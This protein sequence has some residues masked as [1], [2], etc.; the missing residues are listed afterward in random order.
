MTKSFRPDRVGALI[1]RELSVLFRDS[2]NVFK[3][4]LL[5]VTEVRIPSDL[6]T[7]TVWVSIFNEVDDVEEIF[8]L[9]KLKAGYYRH[10]LSGRVHLRRVP[11]LHFKL[12]KTLET[13]RRIDS[14]L[15]ESG[16]RE[17]IESEEGNDEL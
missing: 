12:D 11:E 14:L 6:R 15:E 10:L 9:L 7:A 17:I 8:K 1:K 3:G 2:V 13:A 16:I 4:G 5:T